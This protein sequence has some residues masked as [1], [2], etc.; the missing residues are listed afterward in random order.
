MRAGDGHALR[1]R[2]PNAGPA[3][4]ACHRPPH[5]AAAGIS[6]R[7]GAEDLNRHKW[8]LTATLRRRRIPS[9]ELTPVLT[10]PSVRP[11]VRPP[12]CFVQGRTSCPHLPLLRPYL[13]AHKLTADNG[14]PRIR[15][16]ICRSFGWPLTQTSSR[17]SPQVRHHRCR[18]ARHPPPV[19]P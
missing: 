17:A 10:R 2:L 5:L 8:I 7:P 3:G 1:R 4:A 9:S 19:A 14:P 11:S 12:L 6:A 18:G 15:W 13:A 16:T